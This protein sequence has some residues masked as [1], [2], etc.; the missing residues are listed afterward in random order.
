M[1][2]AGQYGHR[3]GHLGQAGAHIGR[4]R[5][6]IATRNGM[7]RIDPGHGVAEVPL[8][9]QGGVPYTVGADLLG[10]HPWQMPADP[11]PQMVIPAGEDRPP[12]GVPQQLPA[13]RC[14]PL[15]AVLHEAGPSDGQSI[16]SAHTAKRRKT[17]PRCRRPRAATLPDPGT[18]T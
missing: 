3:G 5:A 4:R 2:F 6:H 12:V 11:G 1:K 7:A 17:T 9:G 10:S 18:C 16:L 8:T 15:L 13:G 14:V